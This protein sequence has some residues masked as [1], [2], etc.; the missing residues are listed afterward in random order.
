M[1]IFSVINF[2]DAVERD[3]KDA[4]FHL[5]MMF[6][7]GKRV[8]KNYAKAAKWFLKAANQGSIDAM[9]KLGEMYRYGDGVPQDDNEAIKWFRR[10][11]EKEEIIVKMMNKIK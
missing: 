11:G 7:N 5:G 6:F 2:R 8:Q 10:A 9:Y 3:H 4:L 1:K